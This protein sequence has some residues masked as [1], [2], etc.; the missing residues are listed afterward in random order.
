M[1]KI[2]II[3]SIN[4]VKIET[5]RRAFSSVF[6]ETRF[7]FGS[8]KA[9]SGISDQP[10]SDRETLK[11]AI[12]RVADARRISPGADFYVGLEGG[13]EDVNNELHEFAW[14]VVESKEGKVGKGKTCT[15]LAPPIFRKLVLEDG[16]EVGDASDIVFRQN[17]SKQNMG[18]IGLLTKGVIDRTELYRHAVVS[19]LIPF[20]QEHLY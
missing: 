17:N 11:G 6:P 14:I 7:E 5:V 15:F 20:V 1:D 3:A 19:A 10:L 18:A 16:K 4:P 13:V 2:V 12:N 9:S 8:V